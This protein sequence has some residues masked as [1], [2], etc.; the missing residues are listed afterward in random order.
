MKASEVVLLTND[1]SDPERYLNA[2]PKVKAESLRVVTSL[3]DLMKGQSIHPRSKVVMMGNPFAPVMTVYAALRG[4]GW[5]GTLTWP[6]AIR[7]S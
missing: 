7:A 4:K 3:D 5:P 1:P 6:G 2:N